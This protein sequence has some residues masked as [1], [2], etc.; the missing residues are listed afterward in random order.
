[1][2]KKAYHKPLAYLA[3]TLRFF[4]ALSSDSVETIYRQA[5]SQK[6]L[7]SPLAEFLI[8]SFEWVVNK[9][10]QLHLAHK[11]QN[12]TLI[13]DTLTPEER[14]RLQRL[15]AIFSLFLRTLDYYFRLLAQHPTVP[16][17]MDDLVH[18]YLQQAITQAITDRDYQAWFVE[19]TGYLL[20]TQASLT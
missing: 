19:V 1:D 3:L 15:S 4:Y 2:L 16:F 7:K 17:E 11:E 9:R 18:G 5:V 14:Q 8:S 10:S 6:Y 12:D 13:L 20:A